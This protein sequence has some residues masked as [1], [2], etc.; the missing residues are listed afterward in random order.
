MMLDDDGGTDNGDVHLT[1]PQQSS[2][3][4]DCYAT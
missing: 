4:I 1:E 2:F 3:V